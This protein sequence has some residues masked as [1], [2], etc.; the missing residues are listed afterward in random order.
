MLKKTEKHARLGGFTL[1][2][3]LVV[4]AIIAI[5]AAMLLPALS[6]AKGSAK[7]T[8]CLSN[9]HQIGLAMLTY[10][11]DNYGYVPRANAP[12]WW[13]VLT[14]N[15]SGRHAIDFIRSK[16]FT[17]PSYP[18][19]AQL[20]CYVVNGWTFSSLS[21][22]TGME[23]DGAG[24]MEEIKRPTETIYLADNEDGTIRGGI[25]TVT[26]NV[27]GGVSYPGNSQIYYDVW[28]VTHLPYNSAGVENSRAQRRVAKS[29]HGKGPNLLLF[30]GHSAYRQAEKIVVDDW[31]DKRF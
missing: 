30:D 5:L 22:P 25:T 31:R 21:D 11:H 28:S 16:T 6:K 24:K 3:L 27:F 26:G 13:E 23:H 9:L 19:K 15:L 29:R 18:D 4:I 10:S 7:R 1:I 20:I 12:I 8:Q 17:C 2:E 14:P